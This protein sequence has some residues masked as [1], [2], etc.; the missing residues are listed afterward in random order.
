MNKKIVMIMV[1]ASVLLSMLTITQFM[2][3]VIAAAS[4]ETLGVYNFVESLPKGSVVILSFDFG[5][6]TYLE[7]KPQAKAILFH[8]K[9]REL[10]VIGLA[11]WA[12][13]APTGEDVFGEVYGENFE[14]LP[15]YGIEYVYIGLIP[16]AAV[17][18]RTFAENTWMAISVDY[19]GNSFSDLPLMDEVRNATDFDFWM[20]MNSGTPG[21][22]EV[23]I[24]VQTPHGGPDAVP[25]GVGCTEVTY[26]G[27]KPFYDSGQLVGIL[28]GLQGAIEY[29]RLLLSYVIEDLI[30]LIETWN[31]LK[32][33]ENSLNAKLKVA[34]HVLDMG[35]EDGAIRK[36]TAFINRVE[37]LR[38]RTL[39][40]DQA[41]YLVSETQR[42][43]DLIKG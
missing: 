41:D 14:T 22:Y 24:Y 35:E 23:I 2:A 11:F 17:G 12:T 29:E 42:I 43:I 3:P 15:E 1:F 40:D 13:G 34:K 18:M 25:V 26:P 28:R 5:P 10:K 33:T 37:M 8:C 21:V 9:Q 20:E 31:L 32:G 19:F 4:E 38:E 7:N 27:I 16:G 6:S 30:E 36:L 39:T